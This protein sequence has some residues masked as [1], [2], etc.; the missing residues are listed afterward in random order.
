MDRLPTEVLAVEDPS[1]AGPYGAKG[2]GEPPVAAAAAVFANAVAD[3]TGIRFHRLPIT[4][5]DILAAL[6]SKAESELSR[7]DSGERSLP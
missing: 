6:R 5:Q 1:P 2:I 3:A 4:R 7:T